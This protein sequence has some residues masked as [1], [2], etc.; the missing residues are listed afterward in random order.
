MSKENKK[1]KQPVK[2]T[3]TPFEKATKV[4]EKKLL[5]L[6]NKMERGS[7]IYTGPEIAKAIGLDPDSKVEVQAVNLYW[8][9]LWD[10][11]K[12]ASPQ[13]MKPEKVI[14]KGKPVLPV[15]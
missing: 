11:R 13:M 5:K 3:I 14:K 2:A 1:E 10:L 8:H 7:T 15:I 9:K 4:A 6:Y 12:V